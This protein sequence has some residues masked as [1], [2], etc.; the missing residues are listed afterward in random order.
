MLARES[1]K[2]RP[3]HGASLSLSLS[4]IDRLYISFHLAFLLLN[5]VESLQLTAKGRVGHSRGEDC[6]STEDSAIS[7]D[8]LSRHPSTD[9][10]NRFTSMA[11]QSGILSILIS[12]GSWNIR[13]SQLPQS[14]WI[15]CVRFT[16]C[17]FLGGSI[18][19][20]PPNNKTAV[21]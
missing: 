18:I 11:N 3:H 10:L 15:Y 8:H 16:A 13:L 5:D 19:A 17:G 2:V 20:G 6:S 7:S 21:D 9:S 1:A 12:N 4:L 14:L